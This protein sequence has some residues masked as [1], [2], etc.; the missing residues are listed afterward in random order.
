MIPC[1]EVALYHD[2]SQKKEQK[3]KHKVE[4]TV[5]EFAEHVLYAEKSSHLYPKT[6]LSFSILSNAWKRVHQG[7]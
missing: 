7:A 5:V 2:K 1:P 4:G 6:R 3:K